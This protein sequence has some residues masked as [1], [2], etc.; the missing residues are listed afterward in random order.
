MAFD[1]EEQKLIDKL[2]KIEALFARPGSVGERAAA[3]SAR[4]RIR[5]RLRSLESTEKEV[6]YKFSLADAWTKTLFIALLRRYDLK[7]YR[8][9]GQRRTTVLVRAT[10]SFVDEVLWP[11][12]QQ[13]SA[14][15]RSHL[16]AITHRIIAEAIHGE[17]G[18]V[19]ERAESPGSSASSRELG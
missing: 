9:R 3:E 13:L 1:D 15:L 7:P 19:E 5:D 18:D 11:Q 8:Y 16:N 4:E 10:P 2:R 6:E 12:Y 14:T 17:S